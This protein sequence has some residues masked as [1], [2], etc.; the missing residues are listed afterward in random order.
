[1]G[2][3]GA[4]SWTFIMRHKRVRTDSLVALALLTPPIESEDDVVGGIVVGCRSLFGNSV[5]LDHEHASGAST[6]DQCEC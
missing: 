1:M 5:K 4:H 2:L 6:V 3:G